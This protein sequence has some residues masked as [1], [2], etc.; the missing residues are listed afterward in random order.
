[1]G[2]TWLNE[3]WTRAI[4][5]SVIMT[6]SCAR[7][8]RTRMSSAYP[9]RQGRLLRGCRLEGSSGRLRQDVMVGPARALASADDVDGHARAVAGGDG[10][11]DVRHRRPALRVDGDH[12][13][14][15]RLGA[16]LRGD[17]GVG[18]QRRV[19]PEGEQHVVRLGRRAVQIDDDDV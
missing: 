12:A 15:V 17:A 7:W 19:R 5:A 6:P 16:V 3:D 13:V 1:M 14:D 18:G 11:P 4:C 10:C 2:T 9:F 8:T